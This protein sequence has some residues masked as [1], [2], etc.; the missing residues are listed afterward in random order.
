MYCKISF[1]QKAL[2]T[3]RKSLRRV[4][5]LKLVTTR[6]RADEEN[7]SAISWLCF[8]F[9]FAYHVEMTLESFMASK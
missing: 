4:E 1:Y 2:V 6:Q 8:T 7:S 3:L 5:T 9:L